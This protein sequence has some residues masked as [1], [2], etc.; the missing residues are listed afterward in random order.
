MSYH[1]VSQLSRDSALQDRI[2][3]CAVTEGEENP[4]GW[5]YDHRWKLAASPGWREAYAYALEMKTPDPGIDPGVIS[6]GMILS[7]V[8]TTRAAATAPSD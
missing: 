2:A 6:D 8:Q 4:D 7:A 3:A 5:A 1:A